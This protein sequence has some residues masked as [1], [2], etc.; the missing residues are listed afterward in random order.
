[1][2]EKQPSLPL[3]PALSL[4]ERENLPQSFGETSKPEKVVALSGFFGIRFETNFA[5]PSP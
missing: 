1:V 2:D 3:T 4:G 5:V